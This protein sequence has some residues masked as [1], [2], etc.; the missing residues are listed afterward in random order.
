MVISFKERGWGDG[1]W[2]VGY[3]E[4][5]DDAAL[6][7]SPNGSDLKVGASLH[8][9]VGSALAAGDIRHSQRGATAL[10]HHSL[11]KSAHLGTGSN[12]ILRL[13]LSLSLSLCLSVSASFVLFVFW[14]LSAL[15]V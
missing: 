14:S 8:L 10:G 13:D 6:L 15:P 12:V 4:V 2:V 7:L 11:P 3:G 5:D 9:A 1:R